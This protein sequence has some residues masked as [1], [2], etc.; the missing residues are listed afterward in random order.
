MRRCRLPPS[1]ARRAAY[2]HDPGPRIISA[3]RSPVSRHPRCYRARRRTP[4]C[5]LGRAGDPPL[6][7]RTT[8]GRC[9]ADR[10]A[11]FPRPARF[12]PAVRSSTGFGRG[13]RELSST[14]GGAGRCTYCARGP[15]GPDGSLLR[16]F[17][18]AQELLERI[19]ATVS[20][21]RITLEAVTRAQVSACSDPRHETARPVGLM[22]S[23]G[24]R[25]TLPSQD[26]S[27]IS[28]HWGDDN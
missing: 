2:H 8:P 15:R 25:R 21:T 11:D 24:S 18:G 22:D 16:V 23:R 4:R 19:P 9:V 14:S 13:S 17:L 5:H 10:A 6:R 12:Q 3:R 1:E 28:P 27:V 26:P 7:E 20:S